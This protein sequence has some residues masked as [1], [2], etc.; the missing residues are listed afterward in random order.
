MAI[1]KNPVTI[2]QSGGN[3]L[4]E[5][6]SGSLTT[7]VASDFEG[8]TEIPQY[9]FYHN[10]SLT[11]VNLPS[12]IQDIGQYAFS[13][14]SS[15]TTIN[16]DE[17]SNLRIIRQSA[18]AY[19][20]N[21]AI[22]IVF[23]STLVTLYGTAFQSCTKLTGVD[24]SA[25]TNMVSIASGAFISCTLLS[26]VVLPPNL[27]YIQS[28]GFSSCPA[29][30]NIILPNKLEQI[31]A[32]AFSYSGLASI[33][34]PASVTS[35]GNYAFNGC[36]NLTTMRVEATTPPTLSS[37]NAISTATTQIQVPMASVDAY[38]TATNWSNFADIIV[39]YDT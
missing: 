13:S 36:T 39:G 24:F 30:T 20:T 5:F 22:D 37:T 16:I 29:L 26:N 8:M 12:T 31:Y 6:L 17:L 38:K 25:C 7:L 23:P 14:C 27:V 34:I 9:S 28:Q 4:N 1:I 11:N 3:R 2:V 35:I 18:F 32:N 10:E 33:T 15:L 21:F 19:C